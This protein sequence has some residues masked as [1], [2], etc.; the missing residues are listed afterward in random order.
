MGSAAWGCPAHHS[1]TLTAQG[2]WG[3][4]GSC[5]LISFSVL[6]PRLSSWFWFYKKDG[7]SGLK[8]S[9]ARR[10]YRFQ[11]EWGWS[12]SPDLGEEGQLGWGWVL[13]GRCFL[14]EKGWHPA[15]TQPSP[16]R[17]YQSIEDQASE[18]PPPPPRY[19][20]QGCDRCCGDLGLVCVSVCIGVCESACEHVCV[21]VCA[22]AGWGR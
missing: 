2:P 11:P 17:L 4:T 9:Q 5:S 8:C 6:N 18:S 7:V 22:H 10:R 15:L 19:T 12:G 13:E 14:L 1:H 16:S 20:K 21:C 3:D